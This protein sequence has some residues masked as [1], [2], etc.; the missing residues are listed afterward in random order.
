[1]SNLTLKQFIESLQKQLQEKP[2]LGDMLVYLPEQKEEHIPAQAGIH[3]V[4]THNNYLGSY[5]LEPWYEVAEDSL[6]NYTPVIIL[7]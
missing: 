4:L 2:E 7:R 5:Y 6:V 3:S 1:M